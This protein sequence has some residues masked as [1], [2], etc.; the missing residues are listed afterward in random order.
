MNRLLPLLSIMILVLLIAVQLANIQRPDKELLTVPIIVPSTV[1]RA[2]IPHKVT[3][4]QSDKDAE[5][6]P[7]GD[8]RFDQVLCGWLELKRN[9]Q[10]TRDQDELV[11]KIIRTRRKILMQRNRKHALNINAMEQTAKMLNELDTSQR[12]FIFDNRDRANIEVKQNPVWERLLA[13]IE[14]RK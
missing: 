9:K 14:K 4:P 13:E 12:D 11:Q 1:N 10:T 7:V 8:Q 2:T 6:N 3:C 5:S